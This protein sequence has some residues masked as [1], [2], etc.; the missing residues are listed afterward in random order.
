[1]QL[2]LLTNGNIGLL[3]CALFALD[4]QHRQALSADAEGI[5]KTP[6]AAV[7]PPTTPPLKYRAVTDRIPRPLPELTK[8]GAAGSSFQDS[9]FGTRL[10]RVTDE[11][12]IPEFKGAPYLTMPNGMNTEWNADS[13]KFAVSLLNG[14]TV[15]F[16][17]DPGAFRTQ[18][19]MDPKDRKHYL[20]ARRFEM[21]SFSDP[22]V[23]Y[24]TGG[25][26][27][28]AEAY[29]LA[30]G[31]TSL[32]VDWDRLIPTKNLPATYY[33]MGLSADIT[34]AIFSTAIGG[35]QQSHPYVVV[36][37]SSTK[38]S[39]VLDVVNS[40]VRMFGSATFAPTNYQMGYG[41]HSAF[42]DR[43]GRYVQITRGSPIH[44][45]ANPHMAQDVI[46]DTQTGTVTPMTTHWPGHN[47]I[48]Y[49]TLVNMG[50]TQSGQDSDAWWLRRLD[51]VN[52]P[53]E[54]ALPEVVA[55]N[56][57]TTDGHPSWNNARSRPNT[58]FA[59]EVYVIDS[60]NPYF[61]LRAWD[62]EIIAV[63]TDGSNTVWRF[64]HH[65]SIQGGFYDTPSANIS[66]DGRYV[67]FT[68]NWENSLGKDPSGG[69]RLDVFLVELDQK[70]PPA[71]V[72]D[73]TP[74]KKPEFLHVK[75]N[76][77]V[78]GVVDFTATATDNAGVV[79]MNYRLGTNLQGAEIPAPF[80]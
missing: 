67:L 58:P 63:A 52:Q 6:A 66:Q 25:S 61:P 10:I 9:I 4:G 42:L 53:S 49:G 18:L 79:A 64:A 69:H 47:A 60:Q 5:P 48:G 37:N 44:P 8:L 45:K 74:P 17:F 46:W 51:D 26:G 12:I 56:R 73:S 14:I 76:E 31:K 75:P 22:N 11:N 70:Y 39:A 36:Y 15:I 13:T 27:H 59:Q 77:T 55:P 72:A 21:F 34:S 29:N 19:M 30:T 3:L 40:Q 57:W 7:Q 62:G 2:R 71:P 50:G 38:Q 24:A 16:S 43:S 78:S 23:Y 65:R 35:V 80:T 32:I 1:M 68:S 54:V 41:V 33:T 20:D 28:T